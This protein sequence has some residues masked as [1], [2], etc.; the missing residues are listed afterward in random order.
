MSKKFTQDWFIQRSQD[1]HMSKYDYSLVRYTRHKDKVVIIC[2]IHGEFEQLPQNHLKGHGCP[3]CGIKTRKSPLQRVTT[4]EF[5]K[6]A[7]VIH[8]DRYDYSLV[9]YKKAKEKV[10]IVCKDH[11]AFN[12]TPNDHLSS[13]GCPTCGA[14]A[15]NAKIP[16]ESRLKAGSN[17]ADTIRRKGIWPEVMKERS[18]KINCLPDS[19]KQQREQARI[20]KLRATKMANGHMVSNEERKLYEIYCLAVNRFTNKTLKTS[21]LE[22]L[23]KRGN[24]YNGG[25]HVDHQLSKRDGFLLNIPPYIIGSIHNLMMLPGIENASKNCKSWITQEELFDRYFS[26]TGGGRERSTSPIPSHS[27]SGTHTH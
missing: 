9:D 3:G 23:N 20:R 24:I 14:I 13:H 4:A 16:R 10:I 19:I 22:N 25:W 26:Q 17:A 18:R 12:Q 8:R 11:G 21:T 2:Q 1:I 27:S 7:Q 15:G 6:K 5:I